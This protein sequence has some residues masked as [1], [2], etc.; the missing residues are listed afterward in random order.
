MKPETASDILAFWFDHLGPERWYSGATPALDTQIRERFRPLWE[1]ELQAPVDKFLT[2]PAS[3]LAA[4]LLFDQ[5]PRNMFRGTARAFASDDLAQSIAREAVRLGFDRQMTEVQRQFAYMPF[6]HSE[7]LADQDRALAL[8]A[9]LQDQE[10]LDF[11]ERH[12]AVILRFDRF[13]QRNDALGR[14]STEAEI[15][16]L[17]D[18][19]QW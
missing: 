19:P 10:P 16:F 12:R 3:A 18:A 11:A 1:A 14:E 2:D 8:F 9:A 15:A 6:M 7:L 13:P 4:I 17:K 5:F